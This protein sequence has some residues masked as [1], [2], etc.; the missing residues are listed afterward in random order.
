MIGKVMIGK[1][2]RGCLLYCLND[3]KQEENEEQKMRNRAEVLLF[4]K[5]GGNDKE[6]VQQFNEV[7]A[8]N[9][10]LSKAG[11]AHHVEP[12][13]RRQNRTGKC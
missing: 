9:N 1:S 4:H 11:F 8:L 13:R 10:K 12:G 3:K 5:C 2:F 7:R 6:L